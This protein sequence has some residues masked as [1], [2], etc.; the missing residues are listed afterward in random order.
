MNM[1]DDKRTALVREVL[2]RAKYERE[3]KL[4]PLTEAQEASVRRCVE[5]TMIKIEESCKSAAN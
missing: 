2:L 3:L 4:H 5:S 1:D